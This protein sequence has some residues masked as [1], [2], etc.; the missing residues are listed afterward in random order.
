MV[1][2]ALVS[3]GGGEMNTALFISEIL[4][5]GLLPVEMICAIWWWAD[6]KT[7]PISFEGTNVTLLVFLL[8]IPVYFLGIVFYRFCSFFEGPSLKGVLKLWQRFR[9]GGTKCT[10]FDKHT[11]MQYGSVEIQ[12][13]TGGIGSLSAIL[14][15]G[16]FC[17]IMGGAT[18]LVTAVVYRHLNCLS[19]FIYCIGWFMLCGLCV[20]C[21]REQAHLI[22]DFYCKVSRFLL[23]QTELGIKQLDQDG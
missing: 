23:S 20:S 1:G 19:I 22:N 11:V 18:F 14:K 17:V 21:Y 2:Q 12:R 5:I 16:T 10:D 3:E 15:C 9:Y 8:L 7:F 6:P 13:Q 4:V